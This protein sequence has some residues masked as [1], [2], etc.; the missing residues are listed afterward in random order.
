MTMKIFYKVDHWS[1][2]STVLVNDKRFCVCSV[3]ADFVLLMVQM[4]MF[5]TYWFVFWLHPVLH[6]VSVDLDLLYT[7]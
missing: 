7:A 5:G 2:A 1:P 4:K 6:D 3:S